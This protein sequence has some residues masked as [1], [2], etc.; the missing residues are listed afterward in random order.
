LSNLANFCK[1]SVFWLGFPGTAHQVQV[2]KPAA[3]GA[4][5][6]V[7]CG[8]PVYEYKISHRITCG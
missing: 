7:M 2:S 4:I 8:K 5:R 1:I 3:R 6:I